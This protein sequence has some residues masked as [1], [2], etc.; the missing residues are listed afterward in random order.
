MADAIIDHIGV[1]EIILV[2][3]FGK[4]WPSVRQAVRAPHPPL[5]AVSNPVCVCVGGGRGAFNV[6]KSLSPQALVL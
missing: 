3:A 1:D 2:K 6:F 5:Q 4:W